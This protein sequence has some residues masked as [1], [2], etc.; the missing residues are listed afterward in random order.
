MYGLKRA[1]KFYRGNHPTTDPR[2]AWNTL[3]ES[4][5]YIYMGPRAEVEARKYK[6]D[7]FYRHIP[8]ELHKFTEKELEEI[9]IL[10][11]RG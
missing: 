2:D 11:L 8:I 6:L 4:H 10:K 3:Y 9:V 5:G 7:V 1:D